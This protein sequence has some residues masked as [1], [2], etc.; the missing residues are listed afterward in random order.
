MRGAWSSE[1]KGLVF[2][3]EEKRS[4]ETEGKDLEKPEDLEEENQVYRYLESL[5]IN[6]TRHPH[7]PVYTV[8][9]AEEYW[10]DIQGAHTKNLFLRDNKGKRHFLVTLERSKNASLAD[11]SEKLQV[12]KLSFASD[13]RLEKYLGLT[14]GAVSPLGLINDQENQVEVVLDSDLEK[15]PYVNFHPN[16]NTA[17]VTIP[18][19]DFVHFLES[20]G[21]KI[22]RL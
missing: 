1:R 4:Q 9:E 5:G 13:R 6:Y 16:V 11:I 19:Q 7:P 22:H 15:Y 21:S 8:E 20:T 12:G 18:W 10:K 14:T 3:S 17:T 2:L